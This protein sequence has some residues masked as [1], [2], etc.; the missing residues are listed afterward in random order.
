MLLADL[1]A[2]VIKIDRH[3]ETSRVPVGV[4]EVDGHNT[5]FASLNGTNAASSLI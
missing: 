3:R 4:P 5:Y 1:G 2:E